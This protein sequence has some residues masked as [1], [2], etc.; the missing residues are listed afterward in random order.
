MDTHYVGGNIG[1]RRVYF[2]C[3]S[4]NMA[5]IVAGNIS[6]SHSKVTINERKPRGKNK[7]IY[8]KSDS[9]HYYEAGKFGKPW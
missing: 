9:P 3:D 8:R 2:Q 5:V 1:P 7:P 4:Y 6:P